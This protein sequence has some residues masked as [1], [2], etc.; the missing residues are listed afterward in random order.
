MERYFIEDYKIEEA[1]HLLDCRHAIGSH[2]RDYQMKC[3]LLGKT[4]SGMLKLLVFGDRNWN[5]EESHKKKRIRY[6][7][8]RAFRVHPI[9]K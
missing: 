4:K 5:R 9:I 7:P 1:T 6:I 2:G 8:E 3:I